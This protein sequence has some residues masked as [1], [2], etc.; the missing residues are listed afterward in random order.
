MFAQCVRT[1]G[2]PDFPDPDAD[3]PERRNPASR[4]PGDGA[5]AQTGNRPPVALLHHGLPNFP[6]PA[7]DGRLTLAMIRAAGVDLHAPGFL[8]AAKACIGVTHGAITPAEV[9]QA[10]NGPH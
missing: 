7:S 8:T 2:E 6:D 10:V 3:R 9:L 5:P 1:H 4:T